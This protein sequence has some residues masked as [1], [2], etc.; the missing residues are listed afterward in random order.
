MAFRLKSIE[1]HAEDTGA[2]VK[3]ARLALEKA[4][5][6]HVGGYFD[7]GALLA[8]SAEPTLTNIATTKKNL[9]TIAD[10]DGI[11]AIK[12][13][14]DKVNLDIVRHMTRHSQFV[15]FRN[16]RGFRKQVKVYTT[17]RARGDLFS[18]R[19][20]LR[21]FLRPDVPTHYLF[22]CYQGPLGW[23]LSHKQL[24]ALHT[25]VT[26]KPDSSEI[27]HVSRALRSHPSGA[28]TL[29]LD[30]GAE[31]LLFTSAKQLGL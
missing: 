20:S 26:R 10:T 4:G 9:W 7:E 24:I 18:A 22:M 19:F 29:F 13:V 11:G 14:A 3:E 23:V 31:S 15:T 16:A 25:K 28:I 12:H 30:S 8:I 6:S 21:G 1:V 2:T 27:A 17:Q 5:V